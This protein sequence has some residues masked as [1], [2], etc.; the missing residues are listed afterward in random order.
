MT[1][2]ELDRERKAGEEEKREWE[3]E[4][5]ISAED[6]ICPARPQMGPRSQGFNLAYRVIKDDPAR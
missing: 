4:R 5:D 3:E 6:L 1:Y 2:K